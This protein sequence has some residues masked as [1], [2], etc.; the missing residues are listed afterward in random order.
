MLGPDSKAFFDVY[1][2]RTAGSTTYD[3]CYILISIDVITKKAPSTCTD[4][5]TPA[6][7]QTRRAKLSGMRRELTVG[8]E[9]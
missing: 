9:P 8:V 2:E 1:Q 6:L 4:L 7:C 5:R 3:N